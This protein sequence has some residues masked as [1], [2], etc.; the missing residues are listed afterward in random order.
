MDERH[1][2]VRRTARYH[3]LGDAMTAKEIWIV[4]HGY[5]HLARFFLNAFEGSEQDRFIVA[6]EALN[7]FYT[8]AD[9]TRV[10][11]SWMTREDREQEIGDQIAYMDALVE[12]TR[13]A[14]R[15][16]QALNVL[17]FSQGVSVQCRWSMMGAVAP[18]RLVIWSG[19]MPPELEARRMG[20]RWKTT[21]I[22]LVHGEADD[23]VKEDALK[24]NEAMLRASGLKFATHRFPG[25]H[26][27]DAVLLQ[28]L[29]DGPGA[30]STS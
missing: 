15:R 1:L 23:V 9:F 24:D 16:A 29:L 14:C 21:R 12:R 19:K 18:D 20:Q 30:R 26:D 8:T 2:T 11:A 10:G 7:R 28:R 17:G 5:G 3:T 4:L 6:P 27:L 22:D 13:S 25:G